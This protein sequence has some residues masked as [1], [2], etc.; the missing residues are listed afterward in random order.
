MSRNQ[1]QVA[2][3][4]RGE[5]RIIKQLEEIGA[6]ITDNGHHN[7]VPDIEFC[8]AGES[9]LAELKTLMLVH[10][11]GRAGSAKMNR[12]EFLAMNELPGRRCL[13][14]EVRSKTRRN[15]SYFVIDWEHVLEK[16]ANSQASQLNLELQWILKKGINLEAWAQLTSENSPRGEH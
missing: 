10:N 6:D 9:F 16:V 1:K 13:I 11:G 4:T 2:I 12:T 8:Y 5:K 15:Y 7:H 14:V 3:G